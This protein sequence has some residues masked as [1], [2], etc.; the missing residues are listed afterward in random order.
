MSVRIT[1]GYS[2]RNA[3]SVARD[4]LS[5]YFALEDTSDILTGTATQVQE[6]ATVRD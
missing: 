5:Y 4:I 3:A 6:G 2:S 1:N